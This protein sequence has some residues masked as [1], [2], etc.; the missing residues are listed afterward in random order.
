MVSSVLVGGIVQAVAVFSDCYEL[1]LWLRGLNLV[2]KAVVMM[3]GGTATAV[4]SSRGVTASRCLN[5][6]CEQQ[7]RCGVMTFY[8]LLRAAGTLRRHDLC[9]VVGACRLC[10]DCKNLGSDCG[11]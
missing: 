2:V 7:G 6:C 11:A 1:G 10:S 4:A 8:L 9:R 5:C 3:V